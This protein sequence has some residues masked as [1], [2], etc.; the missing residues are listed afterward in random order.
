MWSVLLALAGA[1]NVT[2]SDW[3]VSTI[4]YYETWNDINTCRELATQHSE[5][6]WGPSWDSVKGSVG[7][8]LWVNSGNAKNALAQAD[9]YVVNIYALAEMSG[10]DNDVFDLNTIETRK[11]VTV[12]NEYSPETET[13]EFVNGLKKLAASQVKALTKLKAQAEHNPLGNDTDIRRDMVNIMRRKRE[14]YMRNFRGNRTDVVPQTESSSVS[15]YGGGCHITASGDV[16][17]KIDALILNT[18]RITFESSIHVP[19]AYLEF[20]GSYPMNVDHLSADYVVAPLSS[21]EISHFKRTSFQNLGLVAK[22][23]TEVT[24]SSYS[25]TIKYLVGWTSWTVEVSH[26]RVRGEFSIIEETSSSYNILEVDFIALDRNHAYD[27]FEV[28][29]LNYSVQLPLQSSSS[30]LNGPM[31]EVTFDEQWDNRVSNI[32]EITLEARSSSSI[33]VY[34]RPSKVLITQTST[35]SRAKPGGPIPPDDGP[36]TGLIVGIVILIIVVIVIVV[37]IVIVVCACKSK[38]AQV[39]PDETDPK[40]VVVPGASQVPPSQYQQPGPQPYP[41]QQPPPSQPYQ[42]PPPSYPYQQQ[43]SYPY[44]QPVPPMYGYPQPP[45]DY[46]KHKHK[47]DKHKHKKDESDE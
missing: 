46:G 38:K 36:N 43:P 17:S 24:F 19:Y 28:K 37:I 5:I 7:N 15:A 14:K 13:N 23:V 1:Y 22:S 21:A 31:L 47:K 34:G 8:F 2:A 25:W 20:S 39:Q 6:W 16:Y 27:A 4:C 26:A 3:K 9:G 32:P 12:L 30:L 41:Y 35:S 44:Q 45:E 29:G 33:S 40:Q 42:Q 11:I 18:H 10:Y